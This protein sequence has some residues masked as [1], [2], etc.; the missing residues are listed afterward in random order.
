MVT[1]GSKP[2]VKA[3][4]AKSAGK[5]M[6]TLFFDAEGWLLADFLEKGSTITGLY[7][8]EILEKLRQAIKEKRRGKLGRGI[9]LLDDNAP[10]HRAGVV[11][12]SLRDLKWTRLNHPPYSP[13]LAPS[14]FGVFP[15]LKKTLKEIRFEDQ[16]PLRSA[17]MRWL[18][19]QP[20]SYWEKTI[21]DCR[22]RWQKCFNYDGDYVE[23]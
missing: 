21:N 4:V 11:L 13:D 14:D 15:D 7:Y 10:V 22:E 5:T 23:K 20:K 8:A 18:D 2:P 17:V 3:K 9:I 1:K 16:D 19:E 6:L 12:D